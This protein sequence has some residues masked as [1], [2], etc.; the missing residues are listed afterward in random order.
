MGS[1]WTRRQAEVVF[2]EA[3]I[4]GSPWSIRIVNTLEKAVSPE[5]PA[6]SNFRKFKGTGACPRSINSIRQESGGPCRRKRTEVHVRR[7]PG[8]HLQRAAVRCGDRAASGVE[9]STGRRHSGGEDR[10][11]RT[12][13]RGAA[14]ARERAA[15]RTEPRAAVRST[16]PTAVY[17][18]AVTGDARSAGAAGR[19]AAHSRRSRP[20][21]A[22]RGR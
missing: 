7:A 18:E 6:D 14:A 13:R 21:R 10:R 20:G 8:R 1:A 15:V 19:G 16:L 4:E 3:L 11:R 17:G 5:H 2:E 22:G 9:E 12:R